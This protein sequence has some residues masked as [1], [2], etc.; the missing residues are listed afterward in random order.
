MK[1]KVY[2]LVYGWKLL[3]LIM[4][5][6]AVFSYAMFQGGFVS[7]FLFYAFLPFTVYAGLLA[8]YPLRAFQVT[9]EASA[10]QLTAGDDLFVTVTLKRRL[11]FPLMYMVIEDVMPETLGERRHAKKLMFPWFRKKLTLHYQL[12]PVPRGEHHLHTVRVRT[13]DVLGLLEKTA[14]FTIADTIL[15]YPAYSALRYKPYAARQEEGAGAAAPFRMHR[16]TVAASVRN[17]QPGDRF[18]AVDWK[19]SARR[20]ELMTKEFEPLTSMNL[21]LFL[22]C[23]SSP[24]FE[25]SVSASASLLYTVLIG[26]SFAGFVPLGNERTVFPV[27]EG[28]QHFRNILRYLA[29]AADV[30]TNPISRLG[31]E[32]ANRRVRQAVIA[33]VTGRLSEELLAQAE[34]G[35]ASMTVFV[36]KETNA[37]LPELERKLAIRFAQKNINVQMIRDGRVSHV[38]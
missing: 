5:M 36:A 37:A 21:V 32:L 27:Q 17:Y 20:N 4:L 18:S 29:S 34:A 10:A 9:R 2:W 14:S 19:T 25:A 15:V 35:S 8:L 6:A 23:Q 31:E 26:G 16:S 38:V 13:G 1:K 33:V 22:D 11:P 24:S 30:N 7:W 28:E 12:S 3:V